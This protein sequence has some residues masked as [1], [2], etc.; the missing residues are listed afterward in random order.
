[1]ANR[2]LRNID[3]TMELYEPLP[4]FP[5]Y[6]VSTFGNVRNI[7]R[8]IIMKPYFGWGGYARVN[9]VGKNQYKG[10]Y[11]HHLVSKLFIRKEEGKNEIDHIDNNKRNNNVINLRWVSRSENNKNRRK[12]KNSTSQY[13]GVSYYAPT[14]K[15]VAYLCYDKKPHHLGYF[16]TEELAH[17][18]VI[19]HGLD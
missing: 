15:W 13:K 16:P 9:L 2:F 6:E 14:K 19:S 8:N 11:V 3:I 1:M 7:S 5:N 17:E 12:F 10:F 4:D 18:A